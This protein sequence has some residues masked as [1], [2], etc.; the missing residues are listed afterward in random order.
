MDDSLNNENG[1]LQD[2]STPT[3][4]FVP[5]NFENDPAF[6][7]RMRIIGYPTQQDLKPVLDPLAPK[8]EDTVEPEFFESLDYLQN[9]QSSDSIQQNADTSSHWQNWIEGYVKILSLRIYYYRMAYKSFF[10]KK[11]SIP[12]V[13]SHALGYLE[14]SEKFVLKADIIKK[15]LSTPKWLKRIHLHIAVFQ[16]NELDFIRFIQFE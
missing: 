10:E 7:K 8:M 9:N 11:E 16:E 6:Q 2:G 5:V 13:I 1:E 4:V 15:S 14:Y 3:N 12:N